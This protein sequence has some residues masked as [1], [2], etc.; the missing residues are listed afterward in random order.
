M[1][2]FGRKDIHVDKPLTEWALAYLQE[3]SSFIANK[4]LP[5]LKVSKESDKYFIFDRNSWRKRA[6]LRA[7]GAQTNLTNMPGLTTGTY[8]VEEYGLH[9]VV[10]TREMD[11]ADAPL[12]PVQDASVEVAEQLMIDKELSAAKVVFT[13][14]AAHSGVTM[15]AA[16]Q[17][18]YTTTAT[19]I[20]DIRTGLDAISKEIGREPNTAIMGKEVWKIVQDNDD[21]LD[22]IKYTQ[23]GII[24]EDLVASVLDLDNIFV[25]RAAYITTGE[26]ISETSAYIWGKHCFLS[27]IQPRPAK[28]AV[29]HGYTFTNKGENILMEQWFERKE[30]GQWV[31]GTVFYDHKICS[32]FA[33]YY[34]KDVVS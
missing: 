21:I 27:Y 23:K 17:W 34:M 19:I 16:T 20:D 8:T 28:R 4:V 6:T 1:G 14:T 10:P 9:A 13:T 30:N 11:N 22:R 5:P 26:G 32:T 7:P 2:A 3:A 24:T 31:Q 33:S 18:D 25:G 15:S 29:S 12:Q